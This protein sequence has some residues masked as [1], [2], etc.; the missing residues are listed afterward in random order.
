MFYWAS[1]LIQTAWGGSPAYEGIGL[2]VCGMH[3]LNADLLNS[4]TQ[5]SEYAR[6]RSAILTLLV[7]LICAHAGAVTDSTVKC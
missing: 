1:G 3:K 4:S 6:L 7:L 5:P 2:M